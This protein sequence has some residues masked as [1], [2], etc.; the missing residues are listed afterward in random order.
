MTGLALAIALAA[1]L[2]LDSSAAAAAEVGAPAVM[3]DFSILV[4]FPTAAPAT[5]GG[6]LLVPGTVIPLDGAPPD[7]TERREAVERQLAFNSAVERLWGTFRLDPVRR[8]ERGVYREA[9]LGERVDLPSPQGANV[10]MA[11]TLV[12]Y[13]DATA[14]YRVVFE[15]GGKVLADSTVNVAR[16]GR[17]VV[18]G[19]DGE[20]APYLFVVVE[21]DPPGEG[22]NAVRAREV[23]GL[24]E[25]RL[26]EQVHPEYPEAARQARIS[27]VVVLDAMVAVDGRVVDVRVIDSPVPSLAAAAMAAVRQW[28]FEP[29]RRPSGEPVKVLYA[30]TIKFALE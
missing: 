6:T 18:G 10:A 20:A 5:G 22:P 9:R 14:T 16:G 25:P 1:A 8:M 7:P 2:T 27:G 17:T 23:T 4:G 11:A 19:L 28:R 3:T 29:A 12:G 24:S 21:P 15:Q 30:I 13:N 26:V